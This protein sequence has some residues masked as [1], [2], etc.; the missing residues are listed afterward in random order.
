MDG[1]FGGG[2]FI[3]EISWWR[4][5]TRSSISRKFR[6]AHDVILFYGDKGRRTFEMQYRELSDTSK[7]IYNK[8]D[9][10]GRYRLVP[11]LVSGIR[12]GTTGSTWRGIDPNTRGKNGMHW[13]TT[14]DKLEEYDA[15]QLIYWPNKVG[16]APNLK[17]Y[18][19]DSPGV[20]VSDF[21]DDI[22]LIQ[23]NSP[24]SLGYPTQKPLT[25]LNRI[26]SA[27]SKEGDVILDPFCGCGDGD[28]RRAESQPSMDRHRYLRKRL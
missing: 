27:S 23:S 3:N 24:E 15:Q 4:S 7:E 2:N 16:G 28:P 21:W 19:S 5:Q 14:P 17:Y 11:L 12:K 18:L 13:V 22:P 9:E 8:Y 1:L 6:S 10:R 26:V 25:L 20:P